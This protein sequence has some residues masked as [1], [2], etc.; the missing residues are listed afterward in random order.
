ARRRMRP[1]VCQ[2]VVMRVCGSSDGRSIG[3]ANAPRPAHTSRTGQPGVMAYWTQAI[4]ADARRPAAPTW[5]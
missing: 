4:H 5:Q 2:P 1:A 3:T